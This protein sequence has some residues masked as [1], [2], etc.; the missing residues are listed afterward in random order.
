MFKINFRKGLFESRSELGRESSHLESVCDVMDTDVCE[1]TASV[2]IPPS[3][4]HARARC[5][6]DFG[7]KP[8]S[9]ESKHT[10]KELRQASETESEN[11]RESG[12]VA[13]NDS[14]TVCRC[15]R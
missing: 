13:S 12:T 15:G 6:V 4:V 1:K 3:S 14:D 11:E 10:K 2:Y 7:L 8:F 9:F 5:K